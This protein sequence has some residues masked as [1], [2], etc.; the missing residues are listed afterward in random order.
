M[1]EIWTQIKGKL[2]QIDEDNNIKNI[3]FYKRGVYFFNLNIRPIC[4][5]CGSDLMFIKKGKYL[6]IVKN[7]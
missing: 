1:Y 3:N 6:I 7:P 4:N 5:I 2:E